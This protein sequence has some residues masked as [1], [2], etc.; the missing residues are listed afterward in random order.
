[1]TN[2]AKHGDAEQVRITIEPGKGFVRIRALN[3]G[4]LM[5]SENQGQG[6]SLYREV[7]HEFSLENAEGGVLLD[8]V[9]P[10]N[11]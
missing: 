8:L 1:V 5:T 10:L 7:A 3:D 4:I 11:G 6:I 2:A 9:L